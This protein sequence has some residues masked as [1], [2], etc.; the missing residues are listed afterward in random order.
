METSYKLN[1]SVSIEKQERDNG[2]KG[3]W[4]PTQERLSVQESLDLG[5]MDFLDVMKVL[6]QLHDAMIALKSK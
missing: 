4:R 6:S 5:P 3:Y 1:L 2:D